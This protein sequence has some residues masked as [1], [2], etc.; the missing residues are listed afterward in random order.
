MA[1]DCSV[2]AVAW[3]LVCVTR[4]TH[5]GSSGDCAAGCINIIPTYSCTWLYMAPLRMIEAQ[6]YHAFGD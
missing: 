5:P 3:S 6:L 2:G 4:P 1:S